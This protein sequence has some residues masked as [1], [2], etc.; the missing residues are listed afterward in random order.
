MGSR[1]LVKKLT[2]QRYGLDTDS[3]RQLQ[4]GELEIPT[5]LVFKGPER[6]QSGDSQRRKGGDKK[7]KG[8]PRRRGL[9]A[10]RLTEVLRIRSCDRAPGVQRQTTTED[11]SGSCSQHGSVR[12]KP[13]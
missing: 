4:R 5:H 10:A 13:D 12:A 2:A 6:R 8:G 3:E 9:T 7:A 11:L 1:L